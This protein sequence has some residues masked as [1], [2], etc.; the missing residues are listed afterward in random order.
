[1][2]FETL[3]WSIRELV[4]K[5]RNLDR[6]KYGVK[7]NGENPSQII[8]ETGGNMEGTNWREKIGKIAPNDLLPPPPWMQLNQGPNQGTNAVM[9]IFIRKQS[10]EKKEEEIH[11]NIK[12]VRN[13][14]R[15]AT[16]ILV[17]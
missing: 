13:D 14:Y 5:G 16:I 6:E 11:Y 17:R 9:N 12:P 10:A 7:G 8:A 2:D 4:C 3:G 1:M 15:N